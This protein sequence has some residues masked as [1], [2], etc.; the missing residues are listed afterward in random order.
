[1][2]LIKN[3]HGCKH[4]R[5][6]G[7]NTVGAGFH[8]LD[9]NH[10]CTS[11]NPRRKQCFGDSCPAFELCEEFRRP[12]DPPEGPVVLYAGGKPVEIL[13]PPQES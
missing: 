13:Y 8:Y 1:M 6:S 2:D 10:R 5:I 7:P 9:R 11:P 3:C 12:K 4:L